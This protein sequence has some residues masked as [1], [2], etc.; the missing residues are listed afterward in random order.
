MQTIAYVRKRRGPLAFFLIPPKLLV[1]KLLSILMLAVSLQLSAASN[2]QRVS[3]REKNAPLG[4]IFEEIRKQTGF[5]VVGSLQLIA[6]APKVTVRLQKTTVAEALDAC[7]QGSSLTYEIEGKTI[8]IKA[9]P[10]RPNVNTAMDIPPITVQGRVTDE[11]GQPLV[12]VSIKVKGR[13]A[14]TSTGVNGEY[15]LSLPDGNLVLVFTYVGYVARE[16][17]V[18]EQG[19]VNVAL[20]EEDRS[21]NEVVVIGYGTA[22]KSDLTGAVA[23]VD[24]ETYRDQ[25]MTQLTDMLTGTVAGFNA[26]QSNAAAGGG[27]L[28]IRGPKS[29]NAST[30]PMI[31]LDGVIFNG[32]ISDINPSDIKTIDILKDA[33]SA[34]VFGARSAAGVLMIT[35]K[36]GELGKPVITVSTDLGLTEATNNDLKPY[37]ARGYLD[38]RR[39]VLRAYKTGNPDYYFQDPNDLPEGISI[40]Q[41]RNASPNPQDDNIS[42]WLGRL[43][44]FQVESNNYLAGKTVDWYNK[45][46]RQG[47][48]QNY[49]ISIGGGLDRFTYYLSVGYTNNEGVVLGDKFSTVRS[50]LN[51]DFKVT[52][53]LNIGMNSQLA[54]RDESDVRANTRSMFLMS[55]YG[56]EFDDEGKLKWYPNDYNSENPLI[57]Y[58]LQDRFRKI[59]SLFASLYARV[60]L[61]LGIEYKLSFQPRYQFLKDYNFWPSE[62]IV[63]GATHSKG[64]GSREEES[65]YEWILDNLLHWNKKFGVHNF[66][67]TLLY[68]AEQNRSWSSL[69][70]NET[71]LPNENLGYNGLQFGTNPSLTNDDIRITGDAIMGRLNYT[72]LNKYLFT[73]SIRRDGYSAF[74]KKNPR[75]V[76]PAAAFAWKISEEDFFKADWISQLKLRVSWGVNGNREI[77]PYAALAQVSSNLY[78][79]GTNVQMGVFNS[80]LANYNLVWEKTESTNIGIDLGLLSNRLEISAEYYDMTTTDLLMN[81]Q[82]PALTGFTNITTNLGELGNK[83]FEMNVTA[84]NIDRPSFT[85]R[86]NFIFSLNR[87]KIK[88]LFGDYEE[89]TIDGKQVTREVADYTNEW[90][91]GQ[92]IDRVWNY[93]IVGIWQE[94]EEAEANKYSLSPGDYKA[95][96]VD[97]NEVYEALADKLFIGYTQ[98]RYRLGLRNEF[99]FLKHFAASVFIR[100]DLGHMGAFDDALRLSS[101]TFDKRNTVVLPYWT[102]ENPINDYPRLNTNRSSFGGG[103]MIYKPRSFVR[104]QDISLSYSLPD[105]LTRRIRLNNARIFG[106]VRNLYSFDRWPG[107]DPE[108]T[109][110]APMPRTFSTGFSFSL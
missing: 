72:L 94:E 28:Q 20:K 102:P 98:P 18:K 12:G 66:D 74:G 14:G 8:I 46:I 7:L 80:S 103:I 17:L 44:F 62:T 36:K 11:Q 109:N 22:K 70:T 16:I 33:S 89:V 50:R 73:A 6:A 45:V 54:S 71:F 5:N 57:N 105:A 81:R 63:G 82:L 30:A 39:D 56:S 60:K 13:S 47:F 59:N 21:L 75:A 61:P 65:Q 23:R 64:Y 25:S 67:L 37:D 90:F 34:A 68:S 1:M 95:R 10:P 4:K 100:A 85:W 110:N 93:D 49:D 15:S 79:D 104:I 78:Y 108:S 35:T 2:A 43:R 96:D 69:M 31:V 88:K 24:G 32:S 55:P 26:N 53:W 52:D 76:F 29:L 48:R 9:S 83:G 84:I 91:P 58:Y 3:L 38:Y 86:T 40:E 99:G 101:E 97:Q 19:T 107:W 92:A 51:L 41:W 27:D 42:E 77:G 106:S 87:N